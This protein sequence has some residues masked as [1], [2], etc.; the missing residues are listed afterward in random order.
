MSLVNLIDSPLSWA[1]AGFSIG[2]A[3]GVDAV[4]VWLLVAGLLGFL[5]YMWLHGAAN[6]RTEGRLVACGPVY[7]AAWIAGFVMKGL[8]F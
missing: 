3:L 5:T 7:I 1:I 2:L 8:V 4:S 6:Q